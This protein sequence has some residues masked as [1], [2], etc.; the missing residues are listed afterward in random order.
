[1]SSVRE[2]YTDT[3]SMINAIYEKKKDHFCQKSDNEVEVC[4]PTLMIDELNKYLKS[5]RVDFEMFR[6][7][8]KYHYDAAKYDLEFYPKIEE[9]MEK[10][11][12]ILLKSKSFFS[13]FMVDPSEVFEAI[14]PV[15]FIDRIVDESFNYYARWLVRTTVSVY[16]KD[17]E[18]IVHTSEIVCYADGDVFSGDEILYDYC[19]KIGEWRFMEEL[20]CLVLKMRC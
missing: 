1:M 20:M 6:D 12:D 19:N 10:T 3:K 13:G 5:E 14:T 2:L 7:S 16:S 18:Y 4:L 8:M 9:F 17:D 11:K 15:E